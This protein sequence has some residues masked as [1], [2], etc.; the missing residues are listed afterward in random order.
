MAEQIESALPDISAQEF[1]S[2]ARQ[3]EGYLF[4]DTYLF[5]LTST[6]PA[7]VKTMRENF[8]KKI[9]P[10]AASIAGS[11][12]SLS[13]IV[14]M[15]SLVEKEARTPEDRRII[16]GILWKRLEL[17]MP[18]QVDAVFGYIQNRDTYSP[19]FA[20]LKIESPYNTYLHPG[21]P[22]GPI[23]NPGF[24]SLEAVL[25]QTS[26]DYLYYLT[27]KDGNMYYAVTYATHLANQRK[28]LK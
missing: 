2:V 20:D 17:G 16:A 22:P 26:S 15:A 7:I 24:D 4:P 18:L 1:S 14:T 11:S 12:H 25:H 23:A 21:L 10:L 19:S 6:G 5:E 28:Y 8:D 27:G 13:D 9:A 3:Y